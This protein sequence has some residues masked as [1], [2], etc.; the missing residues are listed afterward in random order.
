MDVAA[1]LSSCLRVALLLDGPPAAF[2]ARLGPEHRLLVTEGNRIR[3]A[4]PGFQDRRRA[5]VHQHSPLLPPLVALVLRLSEPASAEI[6]AAGLGEPRRRRRAA[7]DA[8]IPVRRSLR[9]KQQRR[10]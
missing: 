6:W 2:I 4:L 8:S 7:V 1:L 9:L 5:L 3:A 10:E